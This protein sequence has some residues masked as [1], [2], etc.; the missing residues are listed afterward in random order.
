MPNPEGC[1]VSK[2]MVRREV[3]SGCGDAEDVVEA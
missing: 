2:N 1:D 3:G